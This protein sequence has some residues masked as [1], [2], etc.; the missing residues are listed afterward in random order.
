MKT[1]I[2]YKFFMHSLDSK[3]LV[4]I[5]GKPFSGKTQL[6]SF[7]AEKY[8]QIVLI[9]KDAVAETLWLS[10]AQWVEYTN[11]VREH[12]YASFRERVEWA[13]QWR[14]SV[15]IAEAPFSRSQDVSDFM[16]FQ[17]AEVGR[18]LVITVNTSEILRREFIKMGRRNTDWSSREL[19][20]FEQ[21]NGASWQFEDDIQPPWC[22]VK[23]LHVRR[24][25]SIEKTVGKAS[26]MI[27]PA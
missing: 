10:R 22:E 23:K 8:P 15:V 25:F 19:I 13:L 17:Q 26:E 5:R 24:P 4:M 9:Y 7:L 1:D 11:D 21:E 2:F 12:L 16:R 18:I 3:T 6:A 14:N 27:F 20:W